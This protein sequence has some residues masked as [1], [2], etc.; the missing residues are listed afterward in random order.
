MSFIKDMVEPGTHL[1]S[2]SRCCCVC[3]GTLPCCQSSMCTSFWDFA[4]RSCCCWCCYWC[5]APAGVTEDDFSI[6]LHEDAVRRA[7][8]ANAKS[9]GTASSPPL[10]VFIDHACQE[11]VVAIRGTCDLKDCIADAGAMPLFFD[12]FGMA[13]EDDARA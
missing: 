11:V 4:R 13:K 6:A 12:P 2:V 8:A 9:M 3:V 10:G 5:C 7:I 1:P